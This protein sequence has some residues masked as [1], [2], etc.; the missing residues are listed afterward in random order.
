M[1]PHKIYAIIE[2]NIVM[3]IDRVYDEQDALN[4]ATL[5][6]TKNP[7]AIECNAYPCEIG[8]KY[9]DGVFY[10]YDNK[11]KSWVKVEKVASYDDEL[12]SLNG[13]VSYL[14]N[15]ITPSIDIDDCT[16]N[17]LKEFK[18]N[19]SK[20]ALKEY[21]LSNPLVSD[22]HNGELKT[23]TITKDKWDMFIGKFIIH[24][25]KKR[26]NLNST[27]MWNASGDEL[28]PWTD[29]ECFK[30]IDEW[31]AIS[32]VLV[33]EQQRIEKSIVNAQK[34]QEISNIVFNYFAVDPR[35]K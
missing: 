18:I 1:T 22:C 14:K 27:M 17:E 6:Y 3:A 4:R 2:D 34:K 12:E 15:L 21:L 29:E 16:V 31:T 11:M 7:M 8:D 33:K 13:E 20:T 24:L 32:D 19:K 10:H 26:M 28:E 30:F 9:V 25:E 23:Y 5:C 35:N